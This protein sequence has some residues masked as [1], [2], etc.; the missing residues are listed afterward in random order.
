MK[1]VYILSSFSQIY[2]HKDLVVYNGKLLD[3]GK[4]QTN[5]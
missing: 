5:S 3:Q 4:C 1:V 2:A